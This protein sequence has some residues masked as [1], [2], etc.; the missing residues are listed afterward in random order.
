MHRPALNDNQILL[1]LEMCVDGENRCDDRIAK[2][3]HRGDF[4]TAAYEMQLKEQYEGL[5][6][7]LFHEMRKSA[8][9]TQDLRETLLKLSREIQRMRDDNAPPLNDTV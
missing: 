8:V 6:Q 5:K 2:A 9:T 3:R 1:M 7:R 4:G